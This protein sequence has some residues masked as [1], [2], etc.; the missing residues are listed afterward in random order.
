MEDKS[1]EKIARGIFE[2]GVVL[3]FADDDRRGDPP[4]V[5]DGKITFGIDDIERVETGPQGGSQ[6]HLAERVQDTNLLS[7]SMGI[8]G[9][10]TA[11]PGG[12]G[13]VFSLSPL[14]ANS[15]RLLR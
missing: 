5:V 2:E 9:S 3:V 15:S 6:L 4:G 14:R 8:V 1:L 7:H 10:V 12:D 11:A 13:R